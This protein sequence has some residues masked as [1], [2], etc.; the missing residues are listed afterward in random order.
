MSGG[1]LY[2][3]DPKYTPLPDPGLTISEG[4]ALLNV[5]AI[6]ADSSHPLVIE[7]RAK[8]RNALEPGGAGELE[9][10]ISVALDD[11][12]DYGTYGDYE[13]P[14]HSLY[15]LIDYLAP[16]PTQQPGEGECP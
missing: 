6:P 8:L 15:L 5:S 14:I 3:G 4:Y 16:A 1:P 10:L 7:A 13:A 9:R 2:D 12:A 11:L